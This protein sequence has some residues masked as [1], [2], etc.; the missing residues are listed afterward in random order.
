PGEKGNAVRVTTRATDQGTF[1]A[2]VMGTQDFDGQATAIAT[3]IPRDIVF[4]VDQSGSMNDDSEPAWAPQTIGNAANTIAAT[5]GYD[6]FGQDISESDAVD[7]NAFVNAAGYETAAPEY[8]YA[9]LTMNGGPLANLT[10]PSYKIKDSDSESTRKAKAYRWF[11]EQFLPT[12]IPS[13]S[14]PFTETAYWNIYL[15]Y[16]IRPLKHSFPPPD[17]PP[18]KPKEPKPPVLDYQPCCTNCP[19]PPSPP[20]TP[21]ITPPPPIVPPPITPPPPIVPPPPGPGPV[22]M[23]PANR[24]NQL[25]LH[26]RDLLAGTH[27]VLVRTSKSPFRLASTHG[28]SVVIS[29]LAIAQTPPPE[30]DP[31]CQ[32]AVLEA[33][34]DAYAQYLIDHNHWATVLMPAW[35][36]AMDHYNNVYLPAYMAEAKKH[37]APPFKRNTIP[38]NPHKNEFGKV[39]RVADIGFNSYKSNNPNQD[40]A[41]GASDS[42]P[43]KYFN[44]IGRWTYAQFVQDYGRNLLCDGVNLSPLSLDSPYCQIHSESVGDPDVGY[45]NFSFPPRTQPMHAARRSLI[46]AVMAARKRNDGIKVNLRDRIAIVGFDRYDSAAGVGPTLIQP[47]TGVYETAMQSC[48]ELQAVGD[49]YASTSLE[50]G[51][52]MARQH[53]QAE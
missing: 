17:N 43:A 31:A 48:A 9:V 33:Y 50:P 13:A 3:A 39:D 5:L 1:F 25:A 44:H 35:H 23:M 41:P 30:Y 34:E 49:K 27:S 53:L 32:A 6:L 47:L 2:R 45:Q 8:A 20:V 19:A 29:S 46:R 42:I 51:M 10:D 36:A 40:L 21:P 24:P 14:P 7:L 52:I 37:G 16:I 28:T 15:D 26:G 22:G 38:K 12:A 18:K 11:R 4:V